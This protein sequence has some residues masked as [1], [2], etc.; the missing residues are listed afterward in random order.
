MPKL[1]C[2][3]CKRTIPSTGARAVIEGS[4]VCAR[5]TYEHDYPDREV[6]EPVRHRA[7]PLQKETLFP[8]PPK[9]E[10]GER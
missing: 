3:R 9:L 7:K 1:I 6:V 10:R 4:F 8:L 2:S 5:C